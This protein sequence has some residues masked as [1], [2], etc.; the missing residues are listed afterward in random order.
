[1]RGPQRWS[2]HPDGHRRGRGAKAGAQAGIGEAE[3]HAGVSKHR[4]KA[5]GL[6]RLKCLGKDSLA[7]AVTRSHPYHW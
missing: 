5:G 2:L 4:K 1:M 3:Q 7:L 6:A